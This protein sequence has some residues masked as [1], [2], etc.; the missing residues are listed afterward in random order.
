MK[1]TEEED[2]RILANEIASYGGVVN[3]CNA[4]DF[5]RPFIHRVLAGDQ[6]ISKRLCDCIGI[7]KTKLDVF[8][9]K[10]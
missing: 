4:N 9:R 2:L 1:I 10:L 6:T 8:E 3:F 7:K 5:S